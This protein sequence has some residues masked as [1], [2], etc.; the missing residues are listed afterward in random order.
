MSTILPTHHCFDDALECLVWRLSID[1]SR[2]DD[3]ALVLVHAIRIACDGTPYAH[4]WVEDGDLVWD[5]GILNG[6]KIAY[7]AQR[8][9]YYAATTIQEQT[10]YTAREAL[11]ENRRAGN[12]G[13]WV[14]AYRVLCSS[15]RRV[16]GMDAEARP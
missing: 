7:A 12:Y 2:G 8:A 5:A 1:P 6:Q 9:E 3:P 14:Q 16:F 13:P 15:S 10:R 11:A 4:A